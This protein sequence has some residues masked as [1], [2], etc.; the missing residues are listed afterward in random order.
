MNDT[1][2]ED[3]EESEEIRLSTKCIGKKAKRVIQGI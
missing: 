3:N 1:N 2:G